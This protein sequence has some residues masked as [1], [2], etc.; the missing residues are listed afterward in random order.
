[1]AKELYISYKQDHN[2]SGSLLELD[3]ALSSSVLS[4]SDRFSMEILSEMN[5]IDDLPHLP[6]RPAPAPAKSP[7][8]R[9]PPPPPPPLRLTANGSNFKDKPIPR[10]LPPPLTNQKGD[11]PP[12]APP[13]RKTT[14][15]QPAPSKPPIGFSTVPLV[16]GRSNSGT[17]NSTNGTSSTSSPAIVSPMVPSK[18]ASLSSYKPTQVP[19]KRSSPQSSEEATK[20]STTSTPVPSKSLSEWAPLVPK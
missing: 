6:Q 14:L 20:R 12:P 9:V 1:M 8:R 11:V 13:S 3:D 19:N 18:P 16:P 4:S 17:P 2:G 15:S 7:P 10:K 5:L